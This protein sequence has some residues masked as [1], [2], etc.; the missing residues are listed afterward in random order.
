MRWVL[1]AAG[2]AAAL[3]G[4]GGATKSQAPPIPLATFNCG[5]WT[6]ARADIRQSVLD[7]LHGFY[8]SPVS[9]KRRTQ[10][11]GTVLSDAE[12][13]RLFDTYCA[14]PYAGNFT[15]YKLYARAAAFVG[16]AP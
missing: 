16:T 10:A 5:Q 4:C 7:E 13:R 3:A 11:Y 15:L 12:A 1:A 9:G 2:C 8:G 14:R 6:A